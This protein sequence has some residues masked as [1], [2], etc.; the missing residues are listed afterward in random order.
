MTPGRYAIGLLACTLMTALLLGWKFFGP[1]VPLDEGIVL[2][3]P[4]LILHGLR[5]NLDFCSLYT[6]GNYWFLAGVTGL[7]GPG[8]VVERI[9]G[10]AYVAAIAGGLFTLTVQTA[11][12]STDQGARGTARRTTAVALGI[13]AFTSV[14]LQLFGDAIGAFSWFGAIAL[15]LWSLVLMA[16]GAA[17]GSDRPV[18]WAG[19]GILAGFALLYRQD[20]VVPLALMT[21]PLL[22]L[23]PRRVGWFAL[24]ALAA[25]SPLLVHMVVVTPGLFFDNL[26]WDVLRAGPTR[27]LPLNPASPL[28]WLVAGSCVLPA[29]IVALLALR[30]ALP[31]GRVP[32]AIAG[33][34]LG[35]LP[36]ALS[37]AD[38]W[39]LAYVGCL[40]VPLMLLAL[41]HADAAWGGHV[42]T[43]VRRLLAGPRLVRTGIG[44]TAGAGLALMLIWSL[45]HLQDAVR[46]AY[47]CEGCVSN[48]GR[49]LQVRRSPSDLQSIVDAVERR[50]TPGQRL[51]VGPRDLARPN[52][53]DSYLY[54]LFP[55]L[56]PAAYYIEVA[57][58]VANRPGG[59]MA[60][61]LA[62]A[63][64][65]I[66]DNAYDTWSEDNAGRLRGSEEPLQVLARDFC[67]AM[68]AGPYELF[69]PCPK[70][71]GGAPPLST[72]GP[73]P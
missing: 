32:I 51:F 21:L 20:M 5:P 49:T 73:R 59:R 14:L 34:C 24:G 23:S 31:A 67:A 41:L 64:F 22:G 30:R 37:R 50:S 35:V 1:V 71:A 70:P 65:V 10:F 25:L 28:L 39:H 16:R 44:V 7:F 29:V 8:I 27:R 40:T 2:V 66:L 42:E 61:D 53:N 17:R 9:V 11:A 56:Q 13:A 3:Y 72:A 36:Q 63:D 45:G 69:T 18:H 26:L 33:L 55:K 62:R 52:Y 19:G 57:T 38:R 60:P 43:R 46:A 58:A 12:Q 15:V 48:E 6:P 47:A 54:H 4:A 68:R